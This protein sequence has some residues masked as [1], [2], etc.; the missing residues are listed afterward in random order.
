MF[1]MLIPQVLRIERTYDKGRYDYTVL[2]EPFASLLA[3]SESNTRY[4]VSAKD[5]LI[6]QHDA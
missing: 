3:A 4:R 6:V 5:P 1:P 2:C